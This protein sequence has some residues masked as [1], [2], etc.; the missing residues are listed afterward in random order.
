MKKA[1]LAFL[2]L[3]ALLLP[4]SACQ[5]EA[6]PVP[7]GETGEEDGSSW[8]TWRGYS[9]DFPLT[10]GLTVCFSPGD[11]GSFIGIYDCAN[12]D[13]MG[14]LIFPEGYSTADMAADTDPTSPYT[15]EEGAVT[16][17]LKDGSA[18]TYLYAP[19]EGVYWPEDVTGG[20]QLQELPAP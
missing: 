4:L 3:V 9:P 18:L 11:D 7:G 6:P 13:R 20:F 1:T 16:V 12:G 2:L 5:K 15:V 8:R 10:E 17:T 14:S 19:A